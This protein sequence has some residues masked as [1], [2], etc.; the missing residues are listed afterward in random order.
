MLGHA[1]IVHFKIYFQDV[2]SVSQKSAMG[3]TYFWILHSTVIRTSCIL[4]FYSH[5]PNV[6]CQTELAIGSTI[7][8]VDVANDR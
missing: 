6:N 2:N 4:D 5:K 1:L 3:N 8:I 7:S